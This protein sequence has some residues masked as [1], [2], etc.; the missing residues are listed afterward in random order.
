[1]IS[2]ELREDLPDTAKS[3]ATNADA[4]ELVRRGRRFGVGLDD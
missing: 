3:K 4:S 1:M 2:L